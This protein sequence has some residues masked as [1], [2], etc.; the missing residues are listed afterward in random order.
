MVLRLRGAAANA[1]RMQQLFLRQTRR[2][3]RRR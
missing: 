2:S 3:W 1:V